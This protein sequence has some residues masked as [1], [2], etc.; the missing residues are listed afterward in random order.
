MKIDDISI[1][2]GLRAKLPEA[3]YESTRLH[4][5]P[6]VD[7]ENPSYIALQEDIK[8]RL[9]LK[10]YDSAPGSSTFIKLFKRV[11]ERD[12]DVRTIFLLEK[13]C[14]ICLSNST[15]E[16]SLNNEFSRSNGHY[17]IDNAFMERLESKMEPNFI[18]FYSANQTAQWHGVYLTDKFYISPDNYSTI[19]EDTLNTF[20]LTRH[21]KVACVITGDG[22]NGKTVLLKKISIDAAK[23]GITVYWITN[24][25]L[26]VESSSQLDK[27]STCLLVVDN[28]EKQAVDKASVASFFEIIIQSENLRL[29]ISDRKIT[30]KEY[31]DYFD[32]KNAILLSPIQ[33]HFILK[34][35]LQL[36]DLGIDKEL[37]LS[38]EEIV[39][40]PLFFI[41]HFLIN[42]VLN[43]ND[44]PVNIE[45]G[46]LLFKKQIR[47]EMTLIHA[48]YPGVSHALHF[49]ALLKRNF[50]VT[51]T[52]DIFLKI[53]SYLSGNKPSK[54]AVQLWKKNDYVD[55][56]LRHYFQLE[57]LVDSSRNEHLYIKFHHDLV[58]EGLCQKID[59]RWTFGDKHK[60][61]IIEFLISTRDLSA[62]LGLFLVFWG[63][64]FGLL[65]KDDSAV[66]IRIIPLHS[67][68]ILSSYISLMKLSWLTK[69]ITDEEY[70]KSA[71]VFIMLN[72]WISK[73]G[74]RALIETMK[75]TLREPRFITKEL[76]KMT[77][78]RGFKGFKAL[79]FRIM[80]NLLDDDELTFDIDKIF[81]AWEYLR[82]TRTVS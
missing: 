47:E 81:K 68:R 67:D 11:N 6:T 37:I 54:K 16:E 40:V 80:Q 22:G 29:A 18:D 78:G 23:K 26:F 31:L 12:Y 62:A 76:N 41:L 59:E 3:F 60:F 51:L 20:N 27:H 32:E 53:S 61:E 58:E 70:A 66:G 38:N 9:G 39:S 71:L 34:K 82:N 36:Y 74:L 50:N 56:F 77:W 75:Y 1:L 42:K 35:I 2:N 25:R 30:N 43:P 69:L 72:I 8:M 52:W 64:K 73:R 44:S 15:V 79:D 46:L 65:D 21:A 48:E 33:N 28:W 24:I 49:T 55:R 4:L 19:L 45:P 63:N 10:T 13:Y 14:L 57:M 7:F 5:I 17:V